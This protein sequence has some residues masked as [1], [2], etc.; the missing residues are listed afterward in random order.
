M[1]PAGLSTLLQAFFARRLIGQ[2]SASPHTVAAYRDTFRILLRFATE[3]LR[4]APSDLRVE[5]IDAP[6]I[7]RFL[8]ALERQRG[9]SERTRNCR[10]AAVHAFFRYVAIEDPA[11]ALQCQQILAIPSKRH[12]RNPVEFLSRGGRGAPRRS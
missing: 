2:L 10:L 1:T 9:N 12:E 4:R 7:S 3:R 8:D 5:D 11:H 6:F